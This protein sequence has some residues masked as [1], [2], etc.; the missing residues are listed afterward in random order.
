MCRHGGSASGTVEKL[1][2][3]TDWRDKLTTR[4]EEKE[5]HSQ[6]T[7]KQV[8]DQ[9]LLTAILHSVLPASASSGLNDNTDLFALGLD[10]L[11]AV[12]F[13]MA[14]EDAYSVRFD[15]K[16]VNMG[17]F[18]C[19]SAVKSLVSKVTAHRSVAQ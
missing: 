1:G 15:L 5:L 16:E 18:K 7:S 14:V 9:S 17:S 19:L 8:D 3:T 11:K 4:V 10:S 6:G 13:L 2:L 12:E